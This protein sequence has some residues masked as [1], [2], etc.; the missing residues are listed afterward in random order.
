M[1]NPSAIIM[2]V[3]GNERQN[4]ENVTHC[5][6]IMTDGSVDAERSIVTDLACQVDPNGMC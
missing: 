4:E 3:Q 5:I 1:Q 2:C 6:I